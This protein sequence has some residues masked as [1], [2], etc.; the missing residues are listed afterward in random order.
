MTGVLAHP[1]I[2]RFKVSIALVVAL[3]SLLVAALMSLLSDKRDWLTASI[4][5]PVAPLEGGRFGK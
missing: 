5:M 2:L 1:L 3:M 4:F